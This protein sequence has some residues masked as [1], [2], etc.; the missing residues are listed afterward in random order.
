MKRKQDLK[1]LCKASTLSIFALQQPRK[2]TTI[3]GTEVNPYDATKSGPLC[4]QLGLDPEIFE[5]YLVRKD[6]E[7]YLMKIC[8]LQK[9]R[10]PQLSNLWISI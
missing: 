3:L 1:K 6:L 10:T 4:P 2:W 5:H 9:T 7:T 8:I